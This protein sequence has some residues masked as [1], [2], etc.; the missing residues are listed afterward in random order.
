M[1]GLVDVLL[2]PVARLLGRLR[3]W[4]KFALIGAVL[5]APGLYAAKS[6][7]SVQGASVAFSAKERDGVR[8][9]RPAARV[10]AAAA[11]ARDAAVEAAAS[12]S[13]PATTDTLRGPL[14][15]LADAQRRL[16]GELDT[17][18]SYAAL[19]AA[20]TRA[21]HTRADAA[22]TLDAWN[23]VVADAGALII[24]AGNQ[25][26]LILDPDLD[27]FYVMDELITK[28][29]AAIDAAG[30]GAGL[31]IAVAGRRAAPT[32]DQ[33]ID[34]A[35]QSASVTNALSAGRDGLETSFQSTADTHLR[36]AL[37]GPASAASTAGASLAHELGAAVRGHADL[38]RAAATAG[39]AR[40]A[41]TTLHAKLPDRLDALLRAR[42][43]RFQAAE[44]RVELVLVIALL[45]ALY[46]FAGLFRSVRAITAQILDRLRSLR[47]RCTIELRDGLVAMAGGDLSVGVASGTTPL[48]TTERD[49]LGDIAGS[50]EAVRS[51]TAASIE[52]Y[53]DCRAALAG[54]V[55]QVQA[56]VT[57]LGEASG[58][59]STASDEARRA[60]GEIAAAV[61]EAALGAERQLVAVE[62]TRA[63]AGDVAARSGESRRQA[64][65]AAQAAAEAR[66]VAQRGADS[67]A[68]VTTAMADA[69]AAADGAA[70][71]ITELGERSAQIE[72][73][74][75]TITSIAEQTNLLALNAAIEAARAGE[76]GRGFA[77]V[78]EEVR[79]LAEESQTA[80][81]SIAAVIGD[82]RGGVQ[83]AIE[84]VLNGAD[85]TTE[86]GASVARARE[87]F[88][89]IGAAI[90][91]TADRVQAIAAAIEA[92]AEAAGRMSTD[93]AQVADVAESSSA[94]TEQVSASAQ[95]S[96]ASA[97]E[98]ADNAR[99]LAGTADQLR[100]LVE[101]FVLPGTGT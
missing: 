56:T 11:A 22:T 70:A 19:T 94:M 51:N 7:L 49:E 30:R 14:A 8:Y 85:R 10:L 96:T 33:R 61:T 83:G 53:N 15:D 46:A 4:Q 39:A 13:A 93:I 89:A 59:M 92:M 40:T 34:M 28:V 97:H 21:A 35:A 79:K 81:R 77:V 90:D 68:S 42:I 98:I 69:R 27:S 2:A 37:A 78:A 57:S 60:L 86:G 52:A 63:L 26:N 91:A 87:D 64:H 65:D 47:E 3:L 55:T 95:Q 20:A 67:V 101:R 29:P 17:Q 58:D 71:A 76:S 18:R 88:H 16:G 24:Q 32:M 73:I 62:Q 84:T 5:L 80:A 99:E 38:Q 43:A 66:T 74:V 82:I 41:L 12:G 9:V 72:T 1:S 54:L 50:V 48:V 100:G 31:E 45:L 6:Y 23:A 36:S 25:S 75:D 44:R